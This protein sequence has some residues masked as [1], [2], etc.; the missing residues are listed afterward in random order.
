MCRAR[1]GEG[2]E[3]GP[4]AGYPSPPLAQEGYLDFVTIE[5]EQVLRQKLENSEECIAGDRHALLIK[6]MTER[7]VYLLAKNDDHIVPANT[8]C[9]AFA[10]GAMCPASESTLTNIPFQLAHSDRSRV[11][12]ESKTSKEGKRGEGGEGPWALS[13]Q[14]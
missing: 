14:S 3:K 11:R 4:R 1:G 10:W 8:M 12:L 9:G 2:A 13:T 6:G 5:N 7:S